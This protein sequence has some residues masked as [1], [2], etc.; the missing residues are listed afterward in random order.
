MQIKNKI[1]KIQKL[2]LLGIV[3]L[4]FAWPAFAQT[5][6]DG[7]DLIDGGSANIGTGLGTTT[8]VEVVATII[9]AF[10]GILG[11]VALI[12]IIHSG[13]VW[14]TAAGNKE[15]VTE[16][17]ERIKNAVIGL[18]I[19]LASYGLALWIFSTLESSTGY[20]GKTAEPA[21]YLELPIVSFSAVDRLLS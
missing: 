7:I 18:I 13:W 19:I 4:S 8:P 16:A 14:L 2:F 21:A 5:S 1:V 15:K 9:G 12:I 6:G 17:Q 11:L 10:L 20:G 3:F